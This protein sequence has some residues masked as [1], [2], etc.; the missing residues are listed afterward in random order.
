M[1]NNKVSE[2]AVWEG[3]ISPDNNT[4]SIASQ[5][6]TQP[7]MLFCYKCNNVIPGNSTFC[8][9]C[10]IKLIVECPK[11]GAKY[12]SQY[13]ACNQ[14]ATNREEYIKTH[15]QEQATYSHKNEI[16]GHEYV[17]LGLPS[18]L[19]WATCNIGATKPEEYGDFF[20]WG[21]DN[22]KK[23]YTSN[24]CKTIKKRLLGAIIERNGFFINTPKYRWG[25]SWRMPNEIDILELIT[26]CTWTWTIRDS[27]KGM[28]I[29]GK[30]GNSIFLPAAGY[31]DGAL[32]KNIDINGEFFGSY[33]SSTTSEYYGC[34]KGL[35]FGLDFETKSRNRCNI[36]STKCF[37]GCTIRPVC[38]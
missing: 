6:Q 21:E 13:P 18:G 2:K 8:P 11:C 17:D 23:E 27:V 16:N 36:V 32:H 26:N 28:N 34:A 4:P 22:T 24:N 9:Y 20:A 33:W 15:R 31:Y 3:S 29:T 19:K 30:N 1:G 14:S 7:Q 10:Q 5:M 37:H 12:S 35:A 38:N 25:G